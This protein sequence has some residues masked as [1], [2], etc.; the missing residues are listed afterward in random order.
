[1]D[2]NGTLCISKQVEAK[3]QTVGGR[4][5]INNSLGKVTRVCHWNVLMIAYA[6]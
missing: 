5:T 3:F 6:S 4:D 1:M 2:C